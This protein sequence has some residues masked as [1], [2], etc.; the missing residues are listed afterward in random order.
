MSLVTGSE[1][2]TLV[3]RI[4]PPEEVVPKQE[5]EQ[6]MDVNLK[7]ENQ[8]PKKPA[9]ILT[10]SFELHIMIMSYLDPM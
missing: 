3:I 1:E 2:M 6:P 7:V 4:H 9:T 10:L 8:E 5:T